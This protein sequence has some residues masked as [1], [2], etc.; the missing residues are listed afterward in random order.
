MVQFVKSSAHSFYRREMLRRSWGSL[1][2]VE[3]VRF[4]TLFIVGWSNSSRTKRKLIEENE[5]YGDILQYDGP[6]DYKFDVTIIKRLKT[7]FF[8]T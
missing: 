2:F 7:L 3:G 6:D 4:E 8:S 1:R 5:K